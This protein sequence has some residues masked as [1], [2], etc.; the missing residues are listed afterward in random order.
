MNNFRS[1]T[2]V[3]TGHTPD[4][5]HLMYFD[6]YQPVF[7]YD[8][9]AVYPEARERVGRWLGPAHD[10]GQA[11]CYWVVTS[12][13]TVLARSTVRAVP[14]TDL[15]T[16]VKLIADIAV[17]DRN[18]AKKYGP[19]GYLDTVENG[20][21][22]DQHWDAKVHREGEFSEQPED[23]LA[24][25]RVHLLR[26]AP[27]N[28]ATVKP[29]ATVLGRKRDA[30]GNPVSQVDGL[31][32]HPVYD[33][34]FDDGNIEQHTINAITTSLYDS[35]EGDSREWYTFDRIID[36]ELRESIGDDGVTQQVWWLQVLWEGDK[37]T[38]ERMADM[39]HM[40]MSAVAQYAIE[41]N[42][43]HHPAFAKWVRYAIKKK[44][45][46][47]KQVLKRKRHNWYKY[48]IEVP[49]SMAEA[50]AIDKKNNNTLWQDAVKKEMT[51]VMI[52]F[53]AHPPDTPTVL[54]RELN[55]FSFDHNG[56]GNCRLNVNDCL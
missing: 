4:I 26:N 47:I 5:S 36:H 33:V 25:V 22:C 53:E 32:T 49:R 2:E 39:R 15:K 21:D 19:V 54:D 24:G 3:V 41:H 55:P 17:M 40:D 31:V 1:G 6:F 50:V 10:V 18:L 52:A 56:Q 11:L 29:L 35:V 16:D 8:E 13:G 37:V 38:W 12:T 46:L 42:I 28:S 20:G 7:Y 48:G 44:D 51:N 9:N 27:H 14:V 23:R 45:R 43:Q 30:H 34:Q